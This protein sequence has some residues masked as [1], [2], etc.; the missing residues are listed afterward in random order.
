MSKQKAVLIL[1]VFVDETAHMQNIRTAEDRIAAMFRSN[2]V[3][4]ITSSAAAGRTKRFIDTVS[5]L[6]T[7]RKK[8]DIAVVPLFGTWPSFLWQE[9]IT[10]L[11]KLFNKKI[12]LGIHGGS[13]PERIDNGAK[14]FYTA[15][16]RATLLFAP[17]AYF[18]SLFKNKGFDI[19]VIENPVDLS[20]YT[21]YKKEKIR[22]RILWMRAFTDV[23]N[24]F[25]AVRVAKRL[26][27][28]YAAFEMIMA[29]KE[30]PLSG[31]VKRMAKDF[32]LSDK[33]LFPGYINMEQ[34]QQYAA[35]YDIY[36]CT[37]KIDNTP[38]SLTEFMQFGL[39]IVSVNTGGI[40]YMINDGVN[41]LLVNTDDDAAMFEKINMLISN[42]SLAQ[43]IITTAYTYV[44]QYSEANVMKK[45][46][47]VLDELQSH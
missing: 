38:V 27:E 28:K 16:K 5:M 9:I 11:L 4:V 2:G 21:F 46:H 31:A 47:A 19:R 34:K 43:S 14:R 23:Y 33:I 39:P 44:Q 15:M 35:A 13:I 1:G 24:P 30:G 22:P 36:I 40:P 25:M 42:Q 37:N 17:S 12:V 41:G 7:H 8:Y 20:V 29:G 10:R 3:P 32:G 18:S 26:A 45:W 6:I